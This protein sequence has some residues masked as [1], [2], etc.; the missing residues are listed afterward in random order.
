MAGNKTS[1]ARFISEYIIEIP[2]IQR[3]YVQGRAVTPEQEEKRLDFINSMFFA[4]E[5]DSKKCVLDFVYGFKSSDV[6]N[7]VFIPLDGQQRLTSLFLLH[8]YLLYLLNNNKPD[9]QEPYDKNQEKISLLSGHFRYNNRLSSTEF[10]ERLTSLNE[11]I[12]IGGDIKTVVT[13]QAWFDDE[14]L[15]DPTIDTMIEMLRAYEA[16]IQTKDYAVYEKMANRLFNTDAICFDKLY[17]EDLHQG[18]SLYVK[19]NARG[20]KLTQF[21]NWKSKFTKMLQDKHATEEFE[22][23][24]LKRCGS[25]EYK[26]YF[27][28][29][30]EHDWNDIFWHF[31]T[32]NL[33]WA[34]VDEIINQD[35]PTVDRA[36]SN[37]LKFLHAIFF[38]R[39]KNNEESKIGDFQWTFAQNE[40][41]YGK[42]K[43]CNLKFL[44]QCLDFLA[45]IHD[46][47]DF[48]NEIFY[49]KDSNTDS[50]PNHKVRYDGY[51]TNL[52]EKAIGY[53]TKENE[54]I[55]NREDQTRFSLTDNFL[56]WAILSY[57]APKFCKNRVIPFTVDDDLRFYVRECRNEFE[58]IDQFL[59]ASVSL[60]SIIKLTESSVPIRRIE[61]IARSTG[62]VFRP[63]ALQDL[64][65]WLGDFDY[66]G[67]KANSFIPLLKDIEKGNA[68]ITIDMI[69][70]FMIAFD[71]ASTIKRIQ[72][73]IGAG[74]RGKT[75]IG[76][77]A[78][79]RERYFF[80]EKN[81][82]NVLF[83]EDAAEMTIVLRKLIQDF[84]KFNTVQDLLDDYRTKAESDTFAYYMLNY[85][86]ALW[87][88]TNP[89]SDIAG[90]E[91][92]Y[93]FYAAL[94]NLD[95]MDLISIQSISSQPLSAYHIDPLVCAVI[96]DCSLSHPN[97][98][99][100]ID[101]LGR[102]SDKR[103]IS[104]VNS[105]N[106]EIFHLVSNKNGWK[107]ETDN[108]NL[109]S[110]IL[111][112][113]IN[114]NY[115]YANNV[116]ELTSGGT[117]EKDKVKIGIAILKAIAKHY[118]W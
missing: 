98:T 67:G 52:F 2:R 17:L 19:M 13:Q 29:S 7:K 31:V 22:D 39:D 42:D 16:R 83:I 82:W 90:A 76:T 33:E 71:N 109:R 95:D 88:P 66:V 92:G 63:S 48:F 85:E 96:H 73:I 6:K 99:E 50:V 105:A 94:G 3:D 115:N 80:G 21:E 20:K 74:Y 37:F 32:R 59:K 41:T 86:Y 18:E 57:C 45:S 56:L 116:F 5:D 61:I 112:T 11:F 106:D 51:S 23:G 44:F 28:Y 30:I 70:N 58:T 79:D 49:Q 77:T 93:Y 108:N 26:D 38:F 87:S 102:Y 15:F 89:T 46:Y 101:Y 118:G 43:T 62:A 65:E 12:P 110:D 25:L 117:P 69:R 40:E 36:F 9:G 10:C 111:K 84:A 91:N 1:F 60:S 14:W 104:I 55:N 81:R 113:D 27:C 34:S 107:I 75:K 100:H 72:L 4:L 35:Y 78:G 114:L 24:E 47:D 8:W 54:C 103:G 97:I 68:S 64:Y 53:Y